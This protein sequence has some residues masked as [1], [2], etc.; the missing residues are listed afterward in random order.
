MVWLHVEEG[1]WD[2]RHFLLSEKVARVSRV[3]NEA[4]ELLQLRVLTKL[5]PRKLVEGVDHAWLSVP[6]DLLRGLVSQVFV[7]LHHRHVG[8]ECC[9]GL[10]SPLIDSVDAETNVKWML[11]LV[12]EGGPFRR[13]HDIELSVIAFELYITLL[14]VICDSTVVFARL[15]SFR[16]GLLFSLGTCLFIFRFFQSALFRSALRLVFGEITSQLGKSCSDEVWDMSI[17]LGS[18]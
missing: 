4:M 10:L 11:Q 1:Y 2:H 18:K 14:A 6:E 16:L 12:V 15:R 5:D 13:R 3:H 17:E 7:C 8:V 9:L